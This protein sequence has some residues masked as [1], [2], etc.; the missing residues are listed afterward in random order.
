MYSCESWTIKKAEHWRIWFL[1]AVVLEKDPESS[2]NSKET[3]P[4]NLKWNQPWILI[5]KIDAEVETP[6]FWLSDRKADSLE[7]SLILGKTEGRRRRGHQRMR[8]LDGITD[9]M[10]INLGKLW[11][12]LRPAVLHF[13]GWQ[14]VGKN[15]AIEQQQHHMTLDNCLSFFFFMY[16]S[17]TW[18]G[19]QK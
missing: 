16:N 2:L 3:K 6:V 10:S 8:W 19:R 13:M 17:I 18:H 15:W 1:W 11:E 7:K 9:A 14:K 5:L 4:V 12:A